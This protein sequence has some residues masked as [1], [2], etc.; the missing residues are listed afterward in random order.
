LHGGE[1]MIPHRLGFGWRFGYDQG[2]PLRDGGQDTR[3]PDQMCFRSRH[4]RNKFLQQLQRF[5]HN[6][7]R[8]IIPRALQAIQQPSIGE[9]LETF[10]R[11]GWPGAISDQTFQWLTVSGSNGDI[12][13]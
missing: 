1:G 2:P 13:V 12:R 5:K 8:A 10:H 3:V 9:A 7:R 11:D 6:M 4:E